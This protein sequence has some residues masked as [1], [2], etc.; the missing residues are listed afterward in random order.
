VKGREI[1]AVFSASACKATHIKGVARPKF[2]NPPQNTKKAS[3]GDHVAVNFKKAQ[4]NLRKT[5]ILI[6]SKPI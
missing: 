3:Y 6:L 5:A 1:L 2:V 4:P